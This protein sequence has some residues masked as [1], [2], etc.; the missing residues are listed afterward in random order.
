MGCPNSCRCGDDT[1]ENCR[2]A[3]QARITERDEELAELRA[4]NDRLRMLCA[5]ALT[6]GLR[7]VRVLESHE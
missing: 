4:S 7:A 1:G 2:A 5:T 6:H 3:M